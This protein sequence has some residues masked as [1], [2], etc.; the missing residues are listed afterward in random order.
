MCERFMISCVAVACICTLATVM[1]WLQS[2][3]ALIYSHGLECW[4]GVHVALLRSEKVFYKQ[5]QMQ[6]WLA[7]R[8]R[9]T[10]L[11]V[12]QSQDASAMNSKGSPTP[13]CARDAKPAATATKI[14]ETCIALESDTGVGMCGRALQR[15]PLT[16]NCA[17]SGDRSRGVRDA[18][19][20]IQ[21]SGS[22]KNHVRYDCIQDPCSFPRLYMAL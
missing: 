5:I 1:P 7:L 22:A 3:Q 9:G 6:R 17:L 8:V 10:R 13:S 14:A 20:N 19:L 11:C 21:C 15:R 4:A 16:G 12:L 2:Q 18:I